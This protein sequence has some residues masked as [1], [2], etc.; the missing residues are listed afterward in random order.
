M[1]KNIFSAG[2]FSIVLIFAILCAAC[3]EAESVNT[4]ISGGADE[5]YADIP[6]ITSQ[7]SNKSYKNAG[8]IAA[9]EVAASVKP[10]ASG[11]SVLTYQW[12]SAD[13][14]VNEDGTAIANA[15]STSYKPDAAGVYYVVITNTLT[16]PASDEEKEQIKISTKASEP[17]RVT[18]LGADYSAPT[19][20]ITVDDSD[21]HQYVRGFGGM[22]NAFGIGAPARYM[23]LRDIDTMFDPVNGLGLNFLRIMLFSAPLDQVVSGAVNPQMGNNIYFDIVKKVNSY[24]GYVLASPWSPPAE[25][26]INNNI[27]GTSPS[28][29]LENRYTDYA[30]YLRQFCVDM[31]GAGAPIYAVAMQ[32]EATFPASYEGCE[33]TDTQH[34][35]FFRDVGNLITKSPTPVAGYGGGKA[36]DRVLVTTGEPHNN[37]TWNNSVLNDPV[38]RDNADIV[39]Y[40][41]YGNL[42]SRYDLGFQ[43]EKENWMTEHNINSGEG[44]YLQDSTWNFVWPMA[45]EVD[46]CIRVNDTHVFVWWY[47]K[48]FYSFVGDGSNGTANGAILPRGYVMSHWAKY[49]TDTIRVGANLSSGYPNASDVRV[50]AY[51]RWENPPDPT[52]WEQAKLQ[53]KEDSVSL[54]IY[55]RRTAATAA[56]RIRINL[57]DGFFASDAIAIISDESHKHSACDIILDPDGKFGDIELPGNTIISVKFTK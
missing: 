49:A 52:H 27:A 51:R 20:T 12:Y 11:T 35:N 31:A 54:V 41:I 37:V 6:A 5:K 16:I 29:L 33:W 44:S 39:T 25:W 24:G 50:S 42:N 1:K 47:A 32:N 45:D 14:F 55:N 28:N 34:R 53:V 7:S 40:H 13:T 15:T 21:K 46:H 36:T 26:K 30:N 18:V 56:S 3:P 9:L 57:P 8:D 19:Y 10:D 17:M 2:L 22:S 43:Y 4:N 48:R 38:A 23:E